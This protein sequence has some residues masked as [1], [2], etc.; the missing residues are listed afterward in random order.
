[1]MKKQIV[2]CELHRTILLGR[3]FPVEL[4]HRDVNSCEYERFYNLFGSLDNRLKGCFL[5]VREFA[6]DIVHL[7]A[8]GKVVADADAQTC[9]VL[10]DELL[11]VSQTVMAAA[12]AFSSE[13]E[14]SLRKVF[15]IN[16]HE[17]VTVGNI[18]LFQPIAHSI[19]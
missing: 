10:P 4:I 18:F 16:N 1:M 3:L 8:L 12:R 5:F 17:K 14:L 11:D 7:L 15:V 6:K 2:R 19:T 9:I 13:A